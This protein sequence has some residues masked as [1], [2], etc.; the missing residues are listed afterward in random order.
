M[1][2]LP[3]FSYFCIN[4]LSSSCDHLPLFILLFG[5]LADASLPDPKEAGIKNKSQGQAIVMPSRQ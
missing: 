1:Q 5:K 4:I 3:Y 2:L